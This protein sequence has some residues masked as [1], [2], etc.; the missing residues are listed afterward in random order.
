[1][2]SKARITAIGT[3]TPKKILT[4][5][6]MEKI[7][8]T[9]DEWIVQRTGIKERRI[10]A[11]DEF[12]S[13]LAIQAVN[14]LV[15]NYNT[16]IQDVDLILVSTTTPDYPFPSVASQVQAR[17]GIK[18]T[19][20]IDLNA[21]CAGF[22]YALHLANGLVTSGANKK[23]L[24]IGAETLSKVTDYT[25]RTS[26]IL[27]GDAAGAVLVEYDEENPSFIESVMGS[28]GD[29]GIHLY[30]TG[31]SQ[32]MQDVDLIASEKM[33][34]NGREVYKWVMKNVPNCIQELLN[35]AHMSMTD[36]DWFVPHSAN[37]R[38]VE[39]LCERLDFPV[40]KALT[41]LTYIGNTSSASIPLAIDFAVKEGRIKTG[42][43][44]LLH[45]FGGG[46]VQSGVLLKW[47]M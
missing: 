26:C 20:A 5:A 28:D 16:S 17:L 44:L 38:I 3:Y 7:V 47:Q 4:N 36:V 32:K 43:T 45:G 12:S 39:A 13:D 2:Q 37:M 35:K 29:A 6:D 46:L 18:N 22:A 30:R 25:D 34:Q 1:M 8:E 27:F 11:D 40:E 19:G 14:Q 41:S 10:A 42:E 23:V 15:A 24:V 9:S 21:T 31:L 33:V